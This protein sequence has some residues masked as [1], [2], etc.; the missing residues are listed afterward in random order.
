[1]K[2]AICSPS[3]YL[4]GEGEIC[5]L[6]AHL[7]NLGLKSAYIIA[8]DIVIEKYKDSIEKGFL[9]GKADY[10]LVEFGGE[11]CDKEID[12][13]ISEAENYDSIIGIGGGK[14]LDTAK[15]AAFKSGKKVIIMPTACSSDAPCSRLSVVYTE[16]GE[17][18]YYLPLTSNPDL[19]VIDTDVVLN[20]PVRLLRAGI[21]DALAT[22]YEAE[23]CRKSGALTMT[24][25]RPINAASMIAELCLK[26]LLEDGKKAVEAAEKGEIDESFE[27]V[28]EAN[29]YLSGVGFE[30]GGLAAAHAVHNGLTALE[31]T[32]KYLHGEKVAVGTLTQMVLDGRDDDEIKKIIDFCESVELPTKLGDLG[33]EDQSKDRLIKVGEIACDKDDTMGNMPIEVTPEMVVDAMLKL[34]EY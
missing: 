15:A 11:C 27:K 25:A 18:D 32:H 3:M 33:V 7:E 1:M 28:A 9:G 34:N 4:Q 12:K 14:T 5:N 23:A 26:T 21:G 16:D 17:F 19:V 29:T 2:K 13:H 24:G 31:E 20:A 8:G 10:K 6:A 30:S 22:Y